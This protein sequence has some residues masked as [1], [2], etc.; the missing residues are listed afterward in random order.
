MS[1]VVFVVCV[2]TSN[3]E[4]VLRY[5]D[6]HTEDKIINQDENILC[7]NVNLRDRNPQN[8]PITINKNI[9]NQK[10]SVSDI[11]YF[12]NEN[13]ENIEPLPLEKVGCLFHITIESLNH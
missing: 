12:S 5:G 4:H 1:G 9:N 8:I 6:D 2:P 11:N 10:R 13:Q 3:F 7:V